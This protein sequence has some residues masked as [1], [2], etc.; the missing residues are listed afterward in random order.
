MGRRQGKGGRPWTAPN[1]SLCK[2]KGPWGGAPGGAWCCA[3]RR[4]RMQGAGERSWAV[5]SM[6]D[7]RGKKVW[8]RSDVLCEPSL[9]ELP[10]Q[11]KTYS[12]IKAEGY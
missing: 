6:R 8:T 12:F 10:R 7:L 9:Q 5:L 2:V 4:W 1:S 11:R 3:Q